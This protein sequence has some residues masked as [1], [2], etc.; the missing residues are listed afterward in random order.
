M[1]LPIFS[2]VKVHRQP[3]IHSTKNKKMALMSAC[4]APPEM[5]NQTILFI[6]MD[7]I[8]GQKAGRAIVRY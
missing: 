7:N 6:Q 5:M 3:W 1:F 8:E 4:L 2:A